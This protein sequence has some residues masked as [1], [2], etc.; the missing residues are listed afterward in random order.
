MITRIRILTEHTINKIAAGEVIENPASVVKEL[1]ENALDAASTEICVEI[2]GGGR[3]LIRVTDNGIGMNGDDVLLCLERHAT[4]KIREVDDIHA[5]STMGFRGEAI[6]SIA[7]ISKFTLISC[8]QLENGETLGTMVIVDG[9]KIIQCVPAARSQGTTVEVKALFFN[10]PVRKKFQK[11]PTYDANEIL[12]MMS[13]IA[14]GHPQVKFQLIS[15]NRTVLSTSL[16]LEGTFNENLAGRIKSILGSDYFASTCLIEGG[17]EEYQ[18][19]GFIGHPEYNRQ[20]RAGQYLFINQR[21]V[22][23]PLVSFAVREGYGTA[24]STHRHPVYVLHLTIPGSCVDVN[25]HPQK[26]E[27]RLRQEHTLKE[28]IIRGVQKALQQRGGG[29][30]S[31]DFILPQVDPLPPAT[32]FS[33]S[34]S[35]IPRPSWVEMPQLSPHFPLPT[36]PS[37]RTGVSSL[38]YASLLVPPKAALPLQDEALLFPVNEMKGCPKV[39]ATIKH[40]ILLDAAT[41]GEPFVKHTC[42]GLFLV[43]QKAAHS[44][45][46]FE[47]LSQQLSEGRDAPVQTLLIPY[48]FEAT[49]VEVA[50]LLE[51]LDRLNELGISIRQLGAMTFLVDALPQFFG[52]T[53]MQCLIGELMHGLREYNDTR[54]VAKI[55]EKQ[56][57]IAASR[58]AI[59]YGKS[60]SMEEAQALMHQLVRCQMPLKCPLGKPICTM[61]SQEELEKRFFK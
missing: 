32:P 7:S 38:A 51:N 21:A 4:S 50:L 52:N 18:L 12:K 8:P 53:N 43:N 37:M 30:P 1:V 20:N 28:T 55:Q 9:G 22:V 56:V 59:S 60:L 46:I 23:S 58:A 24:L 33:T 15:D 17:H 49:P 45:V 13:A 47:K 25:V 31:D 39:L 26:R 40:Y 34:Q 14:L 36:S 61:I 35:W 57:A 10:V 2:K 48:T 5:I 41:L 3:Q 54:A 42:E 27:V 44:R 11:S 16:N 19:R 29:R 6:P